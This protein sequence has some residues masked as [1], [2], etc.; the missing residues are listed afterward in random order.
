MAAGLYDITSET[1][2]KGHFAV[3][4]L[5]KHCLTGEYVAA[6]VI[7]KTKLNQDGIQQLGLEIKL[8]SRLSEHQHVNIVKLYQVI[9]TK[10]K[11]Y[12]VME[13]SGRHVCDLFDYIQ[14]RNNGTGLNEDEAK[15]IF[16]QI[17][18]AIS[19]CHSLRI[20]HR[21]LKPENILIVTQSANSSDNDKCPIVKLIDFGFSNQ[22][23]EGQKLR[24]SCG[25]LAYSA[26]EILLGN[27][28]DG[29]KVDIWGLG[30]ILYILLYGSNPFMQINDSETLIRILDCSF[31]TPSRPNVSEAAVEL[32][33]A[34]LKKEPSA[35]LTIKQVMALPWLCEGSD[36]SATVTSD[37]LIESGVKSS[38]SRLTN[39]V[40][41][42]GNVNNVHDKVI[43][44]MISQQ[45]CTSR[46]HVERALR[47]S[48]E[49]QEIAE[50]QVEE[51]KK[52]DDVDCIVNGD[53]E[54]SGPTNYSYVTATYHLLKDKLIREIQGA[55][56]NVHEV[57]PPNQKTRGEHLRRRPRSQP[58]F[59]PCF[60]P[61]QQ[62]TNDMSNG[63]TTAAPVEV[64]LESSEEPFALP[65]QRKCSI[66]SEEGSC[67]GADLSG[68]ESEG[69]GSDVHTFL[70]AT[71]TEG[72]ALVRR[73]HPTVNIVV[74]DFSVDEPKT[75]NILEELELNE[76]ECE[77]GVIDDDAR[78]EEEEVEED[79]SD[80]Y[81]S[82][83]TAPEAKLGA[84]IAFSEKLHQ[85]SSS[86][87]FHRELVE[88]DKDGA[89]VLPTSNHK[90]KQVR[91]PVT[92]LISSDDESQ[93]V[94][95]IEKHVPSR[96]KQDGGQRR[97]STTTSMRV[98]M[99]SKSCNDIAFKNQDDPASSSKKNKSQGPNS[100]C[101]HLAK[102][103]EPKMP[104]KPIEQA[105][106]PVCSKSV[107]AAE[108]VLAAGAKFHK[109]C[110]RCQLCK[111]NLDSNLL[112]SHEQEIYCKIC[113]G[114]RYGPSGLRQGASINM[115]T[116]A[117]VGNTQVAMDVK[118]QTA[119]P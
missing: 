44:Q 73:S 95:D 50:E 117:H 32:I 116:G 114:R 109:T 71:E 41:S 62:L 5:A 84:T 6:K 45:M 49:E 58:R 37:K 97:E 118:P 103:R 43:D 85:V 47:A 104:F 77:I 79:Y 108:E 93:Q 46:D 53:K 66:V 64:P 94:N 56:A 72:I 101:G 80:S 69:G 105:K 9:D 20:V 91:R 100:G 51:S 18:S 96:N 17:C 90:N 24:T 119:M 28:Y 102:R 110:F 60:S 88:A 70:I 39:D 25:S 22:W 23:D 59:Q 98:I 4:K 27:R 15:H 87:D 35:R 1:L 3:V 112:A 78:D 82:E 29:D 68:R 12:L 21:D 11:L 107:Y 10:T 30:C 13:Y 8:L 38:P 67:T 115:D 55:N 63:S 36:E 2:G 7:D 33:K 57:R 111:K 75:E 92:M 16:R 42:K 74:T 48:R 65:L 52:D 76:T 113:Y 81:P 34:L 86:P 19:Y 54:N 106:C 89:S 61:K 83:K 14:K 26:P 40:T 99:Q 31:T